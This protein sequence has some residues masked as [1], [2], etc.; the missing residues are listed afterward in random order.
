MMCAGDT[1]GDES[2]RAPY[3]G[4]LA[5]LR[6]LWGWT[7]GGKPELTGADIVPPGAEPICPSCVLPH[8]PLDARCPHCNEIVTPYATVMPFVWIF[9]W[10]PRLRRIVYSE[11]LSPLLRWGLL[12]QGILYLGSVVAPYLDVTPFTQ[13]MPLWTVRLLYTG[14]GLAYGV[15]T[16]IAGLRM[17]EAAARRRAA[18]TED[19]MES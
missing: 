6:W 12:L 14:Y 15:P 4:F 16:A 13:D 19:C 8:H 18:D 7:L 3:Q 11:R 17:I 2:E 5:W 1:P 10:G 9:V